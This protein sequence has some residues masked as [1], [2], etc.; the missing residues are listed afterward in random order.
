MHR[1]TAAGTRVSWVLAG[2]ERRLRRTF[3]RLRHGP[4]SDRALTSPPVGFTFPTASATSEPSPYPFVASHDNPLE[5][6]GDTYQPTKRAHNYLVYYWMHLRD[7]RLDVR[8]VLEIGVQTD[9][10]VR[11]WEE[12]FPNAII[13]GM[14]LDPA[15]KAFEGDRRQIFIGDQGDEDFLREV[16]ESLDHPF[17]VIIDDGSHRVAHQR[18][19]FEFLFPTMS[20]H[21]VYVM[22]D[23]GG[24]VGDTKLRTVSSLGTLVRDIMYWPPGV[25]PKDWPHVA[26]FPA[27]ATWSARNVV[28]IAF[29]RWIVFVMR[30]RN[31]EDNPY[32]TPPEMVDAR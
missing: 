17:D 1:I 23:T 4:A 8:R 31:P 28:G 9:R 2:S 7:I 19:T 15:C 5:R 20:E 6:L 10:S 3:R 29:Y 24:V 21:G 11:M 16:T 12:F 22:E 30:G 26:T 14:D 27:E 25:E 13:Y 18:R 32:L